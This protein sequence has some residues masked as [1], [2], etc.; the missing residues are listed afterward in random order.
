[1]PQAP[2]LA[3]LGAGGHGFVVAEAAA[4]CSSWSTIHFFD[5]LP[6][7]RV[8]VGAWPVVGNMAVLIDR[9]HVGGSSVMEVLVAIG[10]NQTRAAVVAALQ[11]HRVRFATVIH[12]HAYV[13][14]SATIG[15]GS[16]VMAGAVVNSR[17]QLGEGCIVN[18]GAVVDHDVKLDAFV[19][20]AP[21]CVVAGG[22]H[23]GRSA[24]LGTGSRVAPGNRVA[25]DAVLTPGTTVG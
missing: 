14:P 1:M 13:S 22:C 11:S 19:H 21:G 25:D 24:W 15:A 4:L 18:V 7:G 5:D 8:S 6:D 9:L 20:L 12:P 10:H 2:S 16:V 23:I 17:S 3:I